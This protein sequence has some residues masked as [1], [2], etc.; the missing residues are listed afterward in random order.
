MLSNG[1]SHPSETATWTAQ[2]GAREF[3]CRI[4]IS[5]LDRR[6][7]AILF[8]AA[9]AARTPVFPRMAFV[10]ARLLFETTVPLAV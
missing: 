9:I 5:V 7:L 1:S 6:A 4:E 10:F 3:S 2:R 8:A